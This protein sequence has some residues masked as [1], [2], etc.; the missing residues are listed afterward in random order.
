MDIC[1]VEANERVTHE[2]ACPL[3]GMQCMAPRREHCL[4]T[5]GNNAAA[6]VVAFPV[7]VTGPACG[8]TWPENREN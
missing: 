6:R 4:S 5:G 2:W 8:E 1:A 3:M 7:N